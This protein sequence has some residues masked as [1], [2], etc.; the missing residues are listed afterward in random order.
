MRYGTAEYHA[1][2]KATIYIN[3]IQNY[4]KYFPVLFHPNYV[5]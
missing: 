5:I 2:I 1:Y 4:N 3:K